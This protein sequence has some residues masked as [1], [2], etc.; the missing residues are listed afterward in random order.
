VL[1]AANPAGS[2]GPGN[3]FFDGTLTPV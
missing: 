3:V 2:C 1:V